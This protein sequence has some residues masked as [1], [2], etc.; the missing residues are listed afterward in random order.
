MAVHAPSGVDGTDAVEFKIV[1]WK[2]AC[3]L[4]KEFH[5]RI[6][7]HRSVVLGGYG[8]E[9]IASYEEVDINLIAGVGN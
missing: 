6:L 4:Y 2:S 1:I 9:V 8:T 3:R 7:M 5:A